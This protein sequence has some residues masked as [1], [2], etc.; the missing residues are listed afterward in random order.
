MQ[1]HSLAKQAEKGTMMSINFVAAI[2]DRLIQV[3]CSLLYAKHKMDD[4]LEL[5]RGACRG[6]L[7]FY[8]TLEGIFN[9]CIHVFLLCALLPSIVFHLIILRSYY[10]RFCH[11]YTLGSYFVTLK[12][13]YT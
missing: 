5:R 4:H 12:G 13:L 8:S 3:C 7:Q 6:L 9:C 10:I 11:E 2:W 1:L